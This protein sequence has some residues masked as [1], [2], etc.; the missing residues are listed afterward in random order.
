MLNL[1]NAYSAVGRHP[2]ALGMEEK[3]LEFFRRVLPDNHPHIGAGRDCGVFDLTWLYDTHPDSGVT[4]LNLHGS[5]LRGGDFNRATE[6]AREALR[7]FQATLP[8]SHPNVKQAQ[9]LVRLSDTDAARFL[10]SHMG[11]L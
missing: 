6:M 2:D 11:S 1:A 4:C 5:Y 3:T 8:P 9:D 7:I 10:R